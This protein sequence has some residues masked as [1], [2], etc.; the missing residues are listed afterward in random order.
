MHCN[1]W[2]VTCCWS[3]L[4]IITSLS[5]PHAAENSSFGGNDRA[6]PA[7]DFQDCV[8]KILT[9]TLHHSTYIFNGV[10]YKHSG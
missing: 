4:T 3:R 5:G 9:D 6:M 2:D 1:C 10:H 7:Q 8:L